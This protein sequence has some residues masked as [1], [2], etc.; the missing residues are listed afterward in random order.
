MGNHGQAEKPVKYSVEKSDV[1]SELKL[2]QVDVN[3]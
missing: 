1:K 3:L 2:P